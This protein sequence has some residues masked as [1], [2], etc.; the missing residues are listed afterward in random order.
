MSL[1]GLFSMLV[2][3]PLLLQGPFGL[4]YTKSVFSIVGTL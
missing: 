1:V 3:A 2:P 4:L